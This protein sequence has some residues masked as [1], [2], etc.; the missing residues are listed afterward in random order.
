MSYFKIIK[1]RK[2]YVAPND[3][4]VAPNDRETKMR[5]FCVKLSSGFHKIYNHMIQINIMLINNSKL[6]HN[7]CKNLSFFLAQAHWLMIITQKF[8]LKLKNNQ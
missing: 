6:C 8:Q 1:S 5:S 3:N 2:L 7:S 4:N